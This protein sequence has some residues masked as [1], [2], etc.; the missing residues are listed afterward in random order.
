L[1]ASATRGNVESSFVRWL[2]ERADPFIRRCH[3]RQEHY[4]AFITLKAVGI[5]AYQASLLYFF[6]TKSLEQ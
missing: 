3:H 4:I 1:V 6:D 2:G 5:P